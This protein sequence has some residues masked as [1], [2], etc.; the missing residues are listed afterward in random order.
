MLKLTFLFVV[1]AVILGGIYYGG[2][3]GPAQIEVVSTSPVVEEH[4]SKFR[5]IIGDDYEG[6]KGHIYRVLSYTLHFLGSEGHKYRKAIEVALVYHDI[7][8]WTDSKLNYLGPSFDQAKKNAGGFTEEEMDLIHDMIIYHHK[9]TPFQ[10]AMGSQHD[11]VV[12]A[13][14]KADWI[15]ATMGIV[16]H[17]MSRANIRKVSDAIPE[18]GFHATLAGFGSRIHGWNLLKAFWELGQIFYW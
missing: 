14:R 16:S 9:I 10:S 13:V 3:D 5:S 1:V 6:Y 8:L 7:A 4:L 17:G 2:D 15:D 12:N 18:A 11:E